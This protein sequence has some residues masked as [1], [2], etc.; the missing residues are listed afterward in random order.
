MVTIKTTEYKEI[1]WMVIPKGVIIITK[2]ATPS[3]VNLNIITNKAICDFIDK[4]TIL[5]T[6]CN[7]IPNRINFRGVSYINVSNNISVK[8]IKHDSFN[9]VVLY[10]EEVKEIPVT[11][12]LDGMSKICNISS[13]LF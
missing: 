1:A 11:S 6:L 2:P 7:K 4:E 9:K 5:N 3:S 12:P 8:T 10:V 13:N